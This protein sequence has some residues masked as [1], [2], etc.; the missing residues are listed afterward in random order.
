VKVKALAHRGYSA[1][2]PENTLSSFRAAYDLGF[3]HLELDVHLSKD[4]VPVLM[5]DLRI[6]RT[7][8]GKGFVK[9]YTYEELKQFRVGDRETIPTLEE[10]LRFAKD[11]MRVCIELK[12]K[13]NWYPGLEETV[14]QVIEETGMLKQ[15]YV[16]SFDHFA[17]QK[18]RSLS[19]D[20]ELGLIQY[21]ITPS[22]IPFM[23]EIDATYL[24]FRVEFLTDE[25]VKACRDAGIQVVVWPVDTEWQFKK[26][27][28]YPSV[29]STTNQLERFKRLCEKL[30]QQ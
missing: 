12:Q 30:V 21:G 29:L 1:K 4:G 16:N 25:Y 27:S 11:K 26:V 22:V 14:L 17:V 18:M 15:V 19:K 20:I 13:G 28:R 2:Y 5:H 8:N 6:D 10:A 7:T 3:T 23:K 24:S 9:D